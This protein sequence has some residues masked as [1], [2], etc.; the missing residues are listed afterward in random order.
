VDIGGD[1]LKGDD[2]EGARRQWW[3]RGGFGT[4]ALASPIPDR[5]AQQHQALTR[6]RSGVPKLVEAVLVQIGRGPGGGAGV[7]EPRRPRRWRAPLALGT[8]VEVRA[9]MSP[10]G[11]AATWASEIPSGQLLP[12][13][14]ASETPSAADG[15]GMGEPPRGSGVTHARDADQGDVSVGL[16]WGVGVGV[17]DHR[18][19]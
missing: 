11:T 16:C 7:G 18:R 1:W 15:A 13:A 14:R 19:G 8:M 17:A 4:N 2:V 6:A 10:L 9:W 3:L 12:A 5:V